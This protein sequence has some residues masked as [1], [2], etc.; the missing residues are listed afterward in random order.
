MDE[1]K[2]HINPDR[3]GW[4]VDKGIPLATILTVIL[5]YTSLVAWVVQTTSSLET[6]IHIT[7]FIFKEYVEA[8]KDTEKRYERE[9]ENLR[10]ELKDIR[11]D[12]RGKL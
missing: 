6:R 10:N 5:T 8:R 12:M 9:I 4:H 3:R 1:P 7:E 2:H 11:R